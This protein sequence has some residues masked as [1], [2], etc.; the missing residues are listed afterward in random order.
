MCSFWVDV[1][2]HTSLGGKLRNL[3]KFIILNQEICFSDC[4]GVTNCGTAPAL[5]LKQF[6]EPN[7]YPNPTYKTFSYKI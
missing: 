6:L 4:S 1:G 7:L 5:L 2:V 3:N